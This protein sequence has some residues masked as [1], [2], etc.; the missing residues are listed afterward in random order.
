M[1]ATATI[2]LRT[3][4][5]TLFSLAETTRSAFHALLT[6]RQARKWA[7]RRPHQGFVVDLRIWVPRE[8]GQ[9][10]GEFLSDR[11]PDV[12]HITGQ[13][14]ESCGGSVQP[15]LLML[16]LGRTVDQHKPVGYVSRDWLE[17]DDAALDELGCEISLQYDSLVTLAAQLNKGD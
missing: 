10:E 16:C 3:E 15:D 7:A 4:R 5:R 8:H 2:M 6:A 12:N 11:F 9:R 17:S 14:L 13:R 1:E